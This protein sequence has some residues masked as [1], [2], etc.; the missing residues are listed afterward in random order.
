MTETLVWAMHLQELFMLL[1]NA[2]AL[3]NLNYCSIVGWVEVFSFRNVFDEWGLELRGGFGDGESF[4]GECHCC[5]I[6]HCY[7]GFHHH[8]NLNDKDHAIP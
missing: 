5:A 4:M 1:F 8:R 7:L 3:L 6:S 2:G